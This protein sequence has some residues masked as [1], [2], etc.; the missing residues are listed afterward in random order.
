L[1]FDNSEHGDSF[2]EDLEN[3]LEFFSDE[4]S[5]LVVEDRVCLMLQIDIAL[6]G[7]SHDDE[8]N[9]HDKRV[10]I[11]VENQPHLV[12]VIEPVAV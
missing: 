9:E 4:V 5:L 1:I 2:W 11:F 10:F 7:G 3:V 8:E 12:V 6:N